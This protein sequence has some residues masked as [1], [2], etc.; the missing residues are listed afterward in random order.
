MNNQWGRSGNG[1]TSG[2]G[3]I[4]GILFAVVV[5]L[6]L[7]AAAGYGAFRMM[8]G[9]VPSGEIE[10]R[11]RRIADLARELDARAAQVEENSQK[12]QALAEQNGSLKRQ[13]ESLKSNTDASEGALAIAENARLTQEVVPKLQSDLQLASQL[14]ADAEALKKRAEEA[15]LD[16]ERQL[17][18]QVDRIARLEKALDDA[19]NARKSKQSADADRLTAEAVTLRRDL[20]EARQAEEQLRTKDLPALRDIVAARDKEIAT[21]ADRNIALAVRIEALEAAARAAKADQQKESA[22][23]PAL[24]NAKPA[25]GAKPTDGRSP[26]NATLVSL[27]LQGTPGIDRLSSTERDQLE[28]TLVSGECVTNALGGVFKRVPVL[29]LR[30]LMRDLDSDC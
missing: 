26:R 22:S 8:D 16:R 28:R 27:A 29:A 2:G 6:A 20:D 5:S 12:A 1:Q 21:L 3:G 23:K 14:V 9:A 15:V 25:D 30:N 7:G 4:G 13:V 18:L 19:Q 10:A 11:D 17:S 24:D